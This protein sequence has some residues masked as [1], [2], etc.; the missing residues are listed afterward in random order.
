MKL[1]DAK[2]G[3]KYQINKINL[4]N[5]LFFRVLN[6]GLFIGA[7]IYVVKPATK[8]MPILINCDS[9][10]VALGNDVSKAIEVKAI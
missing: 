3:Q 6:L 4:H 2:K 7:T 1:I 9:L 10:N 8:N 5:E